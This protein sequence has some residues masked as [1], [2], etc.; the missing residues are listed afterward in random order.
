MSS[1][2]AAK[3]PGSEIGSLA[4]LA[5]LLEESHADPCRL[6][7]Q[8]LALLV[9]RL[10]VDRA[11]LTRVTG[12]GYEVFWWAVAPGISM[13]CV[14]S[15]P[16]KGLCPTVLAHP[17]LPLVV[18]DTATDPQWRHR[19]ELSDLGIRAYAGLAL[20]SGTTAIGTL[21]LQHRTPRTFDADDVAL[22]RTL[23]QLMGRTLDAE[24]RKQELRGALDA[25]DLSS[26][27]VEDSALQGPRT[28]LPN[29][30]YLDVWLRASLFM[31]RR[32]D[33]PIAVALWSQPMA[34]GTRTLLTGAAAHLRG[35]DLLIELSTDQYLLVMPHTDRE[36]AEV[37][38]ARLR[39][40]LGLHPTGAAVWLPEGDDMTFRS[41]LTRVGRAFTE[42]VRQGVSVVWAPAGN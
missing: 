32:R 14:F 33:E 29:R 40:S 17:D 38:L 34:A 27:I 7:E 6:F 12:L 23:G 41:A 25:L 31:A 30:R 39:K 4:A 28:G 35:E 3:R 9:A 21:C 16:E 24:N 11:L 36:G 1:G 8:G 26:A 18:S 20:M 37:L 10:G 5:D 13:E 2:K 22:L 15:A 42:A 19:P